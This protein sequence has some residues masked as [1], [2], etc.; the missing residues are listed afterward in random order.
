MAYRPLSTVVTLS[1]N[2]DSQWSFVLRRTHGGNW[3]AILYPN[4]WI[5]TSHVQVKVKGV[6][7]DGERSKKIRGVGRNMMGFGLSIID[8]AEA[9]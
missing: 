7:I 6:M 8:L 9:P 5:T 2:I 3:S 4:G 1:K